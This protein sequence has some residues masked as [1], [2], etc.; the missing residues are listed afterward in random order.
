[1]RGRRAAGAVA[2]G[3]AYPSGVR[4]PVRISR[5]SCRLMWM[6]GLQDL[7]WLQFERLCALLLQAE[8]GVAP[9]SWEG[10]ADEGRTLLATEAVRWEGRT[11]APPVLV[12]CVWLRGEDAAA[13]MR[14]LGDAE[15]LALW[16]PGAAKAAPT[17]VNAAA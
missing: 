17:V 12:R 15:R 9:E 2:G 10:S 1:D 4:I 11:L 3:P 7:G 16:Q 5:R 6:R 8:S 13:R 14:A